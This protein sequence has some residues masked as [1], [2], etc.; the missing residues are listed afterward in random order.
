MTYDEF[1]CFKHQF[2]KFKLSTGLNNQI[3]QNSNLLLIRQG[4]SLVVK[5]ERENE[6]TC[7]SARQ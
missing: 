2:G 4:E 6:L 5:T 3:N 1:V 7:L